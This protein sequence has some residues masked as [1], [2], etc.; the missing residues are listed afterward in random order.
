MNDIQMNQDLIPQDNE[1]VPGKI[2]TPEA[3][4][5]KEFFDQLGKSQIKYCVLRNYESLPH[6]LNDS[7][8]DI[9]VKKPHVEAFYEILFAVTEAFHG[10]VIVKYG[11]LTPRVCLCGKSENWW[12][13]QIDIHEG[14]LPFKSFPTIDADFI[15]KRSKY[16]KDICVADDY[17]AAI[18]A[19][20]KEI[21]NNRSCQEKYFSAAQTAYKK[22]KDLYSIQL[23]NSFGCEFASSMADIL[24][25]TFSE[26]RIAEL[27]DLGRNN[28]CRGFGNR[29][30]VWKEQLNKFYRFFSPPGFSVAIMGC[31]GAGKTT[32]IDQIKLPLNNAVHNELYYEHMRP[33]LIPNIAQLLGKKKADGP[34]TDPHGSQP[35]GLAGSLLRLTYYSFD[36]IAGYWL[37]IYPAKVRKSCIWLFDRYYYDYLVDPYRARL[38][39][40][41]WLIKLVGTVV[42]AP[43]L[44][45]RLGADPAT[46]HSRKPEL[47]IEEV[48]RQIERLREFCDKNKRAVWINTGCSIEESV[49]KTLEV[50]T[51]RMAARY[52]K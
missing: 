12:G 47:S 41:E 30:Q 49:D 2:E 23:K 6:N 17:D 50:I 3:P 20:L 32:V 16:Y 24:N 42:P 34:T 15:L 25:K 43:N 5:L 9:L 7:D 29:F 21:L 52:A 31:D 8:L 13:I 10:Q 39:L 48:Q 33:N 37:K 14:I 36:Y 28:L 44:I 1:S 38:S 19:F 51:S 26:R 46:I 45:L 40:P 35:S 18:V 27:A 22:N 11:E 4:F